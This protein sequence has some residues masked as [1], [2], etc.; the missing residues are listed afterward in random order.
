MEPQHQYTNVHSH[1][2]HN[3]DD[4]STEVESLVG[5]EKQWRSDSDY[6]NR[7]PRSRRQRLCSSIIPALRWLSVIG[8]QL[9]IVGLLARDQGLLESTSWRSRSTSANEVGGDVTGWGPHSMCIHGTDVKNE[10][11]R[12]TAVPT[13][14]TTFKINQTFAPYNTSEFFKPETLRAWNELMPSKLPKVVPLTSNCFCY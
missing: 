6:D 12:F 10:A 14:I 11:N 8:L 9:I 4:S 7:T 13:Q 1:D 3:D 2:H 5:M